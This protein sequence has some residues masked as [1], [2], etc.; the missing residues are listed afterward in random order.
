MNMPRL[1]AFLSSAC[2]VCSQAHL[3]LSHMSQRG[4]NTCS[5]TTPHACM[6]PRTSSERVPAWEPGG[7]ISAR[8]SPPQVRGQP[9]RFN[10]AQLHDVAVGVGS[11]ASAALERRVWVV[12]REH[13]SGRHTTLEHREPR[14]VD[15]QKRVVARRHGLVGGV[16]NGVDVGGVHGSPARVRAGSYAPR[17]RRNVEP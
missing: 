1:R 12:K 3:T 4:R 6:Q 13:V 11:W 17:E 7:W 2:L 8:P 14:L 15:V 9:R 10:G 5:E 16:D